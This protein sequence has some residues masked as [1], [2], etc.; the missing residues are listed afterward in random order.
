MGR[1]LLYLLECSVTL[2]LLYSLYVLL[3]RKETFFSVNRF[4]LLA[5]LAFS[6]LIPL[7]SFELSSSKEYVMT[8]PIQQLS[9]AR[10]SYYE[11]L[12]D[13][14]EGNG[15][16]GN[17]VAVTQL[18]T[19]RNTLS[20][21][22]M[23]L[24]VY[25]IGVI[26]ILFRLIWTYHWIHELKKNNHKEEMEGVTVVKLPQRIAPFS[27]LNSVFVSEELLETK[28]FVQ[29]LA[30]EKT[31]IKQRHSVDLLIVQLLAAVLWFNPVVWLLIKSLKTTHEYIADKK[32]ITQ[33]YSLV[34]YQSLLLRQLISNNSFGL[35]H[36]FNLSFIKKRITMMKIKETGW[37]GK[38]KFVLVLSVVTVFSLVMIQCN[39]AMDQDSDLTIDEQ[40]TGLQSGS[41]SIMPVLETEM[42]PVL[43]QNDFRFNGNQSDILNL[44]VSDDQIIL[45]GS[46]VKV[47]ELAARLSAFPSEN[48]VVVTRIHRNQSMELVRSVQWEL[49][50]A[51]KRKLLYIGVSSD[52]QLVE[53]P[54]LLPPVP[55]SAE[56]IQLPH[57]DDAY[58]KE[59]DMDLLKIKLGDD[60][61]SANQQLVYDFV[62]DQMAKGKSN[63]VVSAKYVDTDTY[64]QYLRNFNYIYSGFNQIY[65][66]R[67]QEMFG[68][69]FYDLDKSIPEDKKQYMAVRK[70]IPRA[71]SIAD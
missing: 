22:M 19:D 12:A 37:T 66:E 8:E 30:H 47:D 10:V 62:K 57:I 53:I 56:G 60:A 1:L 50:R 13:W 35:V 41:N 58:A 4:F 54:L 23:V 6:F 36:N 11:A 70:G 24:A 7:M 32:M 38:V 64:D 5:I 25:A 55:E 71:I 3:L 49:R 16:S 46:V 31:H 39:S 42:L 28:E 63:Y 29:I 21:V 33:G 59:H 26:A 43:P 9:T 40:N 48:S 67:S 45:N 51:N 69:R 44:S 17:V 2:V 14:S 61:G 65:E 27:F 68:R 18:P 20:L 52:H 15:V 34:E